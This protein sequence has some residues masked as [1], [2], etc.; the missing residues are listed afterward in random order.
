MS[1]KNIR[2]SVLDQ[3][4]VRKGVSAERAVQETI[5]LAK[6]T[7]G[8]GYTRFWVSEHHNTGSLAGST[9][10]V[11]IAYLAS[12]TKNIRVGSGGVMMP[13]HSALKVAE[14]FRMLEALAPG[15]IDLGMGRAPGTDRITASM[16]NP[17]NQ[18]REQDFVEQ[19]GDLVNYF[20]DRAVPGTIQQKI[21]AIPQVKTVPAMWLLSS[22]GQSGLFAGHF[23]MGFS[24]AHFINPVG[25]AQAVKMYKDRF[26]PSEDMK[27]PQANMAI[28][29][30][31]SEDEEKIA[32]HK[33]IMDYRFIQFEKGAGILPLGYEDVKD[34]EYTLPEQDRIRY[35]RQRVVAG[36]PAMVNERLNNLAES[37]GVDEILAVTITENFEDRLQS[38]K[39]LAEL[40]NL[41]IPNQ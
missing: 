37:Y 12:Q 36:T 23:G 11:L 40:F 4:P 29:V 34:A 30:F 41:Q 21:R 19:L 16:L 15:R 27:E 39:L 2:L 5:A 13:N 6:Y 25:G 20:H 24:F 1:T 28:F 3:S 38:Y 14:N 31:C 7:D 33:A 35:N 10:E 17:S 8:L 22:S 9:P 18:F 26:Q 32:Q